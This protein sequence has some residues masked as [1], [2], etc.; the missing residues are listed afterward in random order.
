MYIDVPSSE[1]TA[2]PAVC[3]YIHAPSS[4]RTAIPAVCINIDVP[5]SDCYTGC[6][7]VY[8]RA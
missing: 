5:S 3:M 6:M 4:D 2:I 7:Y 1:R 8:I